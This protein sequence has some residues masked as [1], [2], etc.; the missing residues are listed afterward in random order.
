[1]TTILY[2]I[3]FDN[4]WT[5]IGKWAVMYMCVRGIH[6]ASF[7]SIVRFDL[8]LFWQCIIL[9]FQFIK[10]K[11]KMPFKYT[12]GAQWHLSMPFD[13]FWC[14]E[15][16]A[17]FVY[18]KAAMTVLINKVNFVSVSTIRPYFETVRQCGIY[19]VFHLINYKIKYS[20]KYTN[21]VLWKPSVANV[22]WPFWC[23]E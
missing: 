12:N 23:S 9:P 7:P 21:D 11:N 20:F 19:F 15:Y 13:H 5:K 14:S 17:I 10:Y 3:I 22:I 2:I 1:M 4:L 16:T 18:D 6:F 8:E